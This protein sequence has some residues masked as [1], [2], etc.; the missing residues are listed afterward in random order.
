MVQVRAGR[1]C[2]HLDAGV[3]QM[4]QELHGAPAFRLSGWA[5][6][7]CAFRPRVHG[8]MNRS[9]EVAVWMHTKREG[10]GEALESRR[11]VLSRGPGGQV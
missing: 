5:A 11:T 2:G 3:S 1:R 4:W 9:L 8:L 6:A 10:A 7:G